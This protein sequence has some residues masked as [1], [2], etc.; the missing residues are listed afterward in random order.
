MKT[1]QFSAGSL[2]NN[3]STTILKFV[4]RLY[5][6]SSR[7]ISIPFKF[8]ISPRIKLFKSRYENYYTTNL[9]LPIF[10]LIVGVFLLSNSTALAA[11]ITPENLIKLTNIN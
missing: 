7:Y 9:C 10:L 8:F 1:K 5:K 11:D 3:Y 4:L 6:K 2:H